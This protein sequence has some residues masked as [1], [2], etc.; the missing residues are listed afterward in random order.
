[1]RCLKSYPLP[2][3]KSGSIPEGP[4][5]LA[6]PI[7]HR[8]EKVIVRPADDPKS[9]PTVHLVVMED[10]GSSPTVLKLIAYTEDDA[11]DMN[12]KSA[13]CIDTFLFGGKVYGLFDARKMKIGA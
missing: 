8:F 3:T 9:K 12:V 5:H 4:F 7:N 10:N 1:M 2:L 6:L 11:I 13:D